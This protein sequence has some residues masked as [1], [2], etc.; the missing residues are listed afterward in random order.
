MKVT[1]I[2]IVIGSLGTIPKIMEIRRQVE[3][4]QTTALLRPARILRRVL[5]TCC[6]SNSNEKPS[7]TVGENS[8]EKNNDNNVLGASKVFSFYRLL[9]QVYFMYTS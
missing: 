5:K 7:A 1:M 6:H 9:L 4:I 8:Q 3:T 2:P